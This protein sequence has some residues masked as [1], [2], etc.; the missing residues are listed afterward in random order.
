MRD[1]HATAVG[2]AQVEALIVHDLFHDVGVEMVEVL[3]TSSDR[4]SE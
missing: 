3:A 1:I 2:L 4:V